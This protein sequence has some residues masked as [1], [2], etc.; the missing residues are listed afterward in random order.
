[1]RL[2]QPSPH[3]GERIARLIADKNARLVRVDVVL[4]GSEAGAGPDECAPE[5]G[6]LLPEQLELCARL[7]ALC[8]NLRAVTFEDPR[9]TDGGE[10]DATSAASLAALRA[11]TARWVS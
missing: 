1:M 7:L 10:L 4:T 6:S 11:V 2:P 8:P 5:L 3:L 9:L